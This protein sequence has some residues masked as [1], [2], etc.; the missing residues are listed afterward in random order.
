MTV[1]GFVFKL[2]SL[3]VCRRFELA[4][5]PSLY[6]LRVNRLS[7]GVQTSRH[8]PRESGGVPTLPVPESERKEGGQ[9]WNFVLGE[10]SKNG[11]RGTVQKWSTEVRGRRDKVIQKWSRK[12]RDILVLV[13]NIFP[14]PFPAKDVVKLTGKAENALPSKCKSAAVHQ[15]ETKLDEKGSRK[16]F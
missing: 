12:F 15:K 10:G 3:R 13:F 14:R 9:N 1:L 6:S 2:C 7:Q 5:P 11:T 16:S 8:L 4:Y